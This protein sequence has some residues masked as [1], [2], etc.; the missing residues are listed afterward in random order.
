MV[1]SNGTLDIHLDIH[2]DIP[3]LQLSA[4]SSG[5]EARDKERFSEI[6]E[7]SLLNPSEEWLVFQAIKLNMS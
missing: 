3:S 7:G 6:F 5:V 2:L 4:F 1:T